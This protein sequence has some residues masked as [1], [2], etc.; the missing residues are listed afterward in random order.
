MLRSTFLFQLSPPWHVNFHFRLDYLLFPCFCLLQ[1]IK[2]HHHEEGADSSGLEWQCWEGIWLWVDMQPVWTTVFLLWKVWSDSSVLLHL[3]PASLM[4]ECFILWSTKFG[5]C[6]VSCNS[7]RL[8]PS[9]VG[10]V[11]HLHRQGIVVVLS[12]YIEACEYCTIENQFVYFFA[13]HVLYH[14]FVNHS[15]SYIYTCPW[16]PSVDFIT[17]IHGLC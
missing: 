15:P 5:H 3:L 2:L 4:L 12:H 8:F 16:V 9:F 11:Y 17:L 1:G 7:I 10:Y 14:Q 13:K 6:L